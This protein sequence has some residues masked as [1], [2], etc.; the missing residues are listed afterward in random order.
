MEVEVGHIPSTYTQPLY[1][2]TAYVKKANC[3]TISYGKIA[4]ATDFMVSFFLWCINQLDSTKLSLIVCD[5]SLLAVHTLPHSQQIPN[6]KTFYWHITATFIQRWHVSTAPSPYVYA[7]R[8]HEVSL[9]INSERVTT[10]LLSHCVVRQ[11]FH[12]LY[13]KRLCGRLGSAQKGG[14]HPG[15]GRGQANRVWVLCTVQ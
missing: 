9:R 2:N 4:S 15:E 8:E 5:S 7:L 10:W 1:R 6:V 11:P 13:C 12:K 3:E 14:K